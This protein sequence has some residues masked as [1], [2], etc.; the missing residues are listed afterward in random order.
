MKPYFADDEIAGLQ[1]A[2]VD[3]LV[4]ARRLA[5]VPFTITEGLA[6]GGSHVENT[7]HA[8][9]LAVD[10]RCHDSVSRF[11]IV[12]AL[13]EAGFTRVGVYDKHVHA[14]CDPGLPQGVLWVGRS[15]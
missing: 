1:P 3:R 6:A 5:M 15:S 10:L 2:L 8:R 9:G 4:E 7:A 13:L 12:K 14:D 11:K